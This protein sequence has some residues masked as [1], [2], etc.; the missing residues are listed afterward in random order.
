MYLVDGH[1]RHRA[2]QIARKRGVPIEWVSIVAFQGNDADRVARILTSQEGEKLS[3]LEVAKGYKRLQGLGF[4]PEEI[5]TKVFKSRSYVD[6]LLTLANANTDVQKLVQAGHV[7]AAVAIKQ[8]KVKGEA[9]GKF[10]SES[11]SKAQKAGKKKITD[12][13]IKVPVKWYKKVPVTG[14]YVTEDDGTYFIAEE[15]AGAEVYAPYYG[16]IPEVKK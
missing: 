12:K 16:P 4:A 10:L 1:R 5:A 11:V 8:V 2:M 14:T 13:D 6:Q 15:E 3:Q 7:P 9:A